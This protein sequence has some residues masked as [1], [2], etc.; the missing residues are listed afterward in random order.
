MIWKRVSTAG[1]C[2]STFPL[3]G[4]FGL[5]GLKLLPMLKRRG[6]RVGGIR[7]M[8]ETQTQRSFGAGRKHTIN[9]LIA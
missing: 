8:A 5:M 6:I 1:P 4:T 2:C 9:W 3:A 7:E